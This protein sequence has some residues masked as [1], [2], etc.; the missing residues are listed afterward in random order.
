MKLSR[1]QVSLQGNA[2]GRSEWSTICNEHSFSETTAVA[3]TCVTGATTKR[4][5][6]LF[7]L[8]QD[9]SGSS[10]L[11]DASLLKGDCGERASENLRVLEVDQR[12]ARGESRT[13]HVRAVES[14]SHPH[15][16]DDYVHLFREEVAESD[17]RQKTE[18]PG[19]IRNVVRPV[20]LNK[21]IEP[22]PCEP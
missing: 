22:V 3:P 9:D 12:D 7:A 20:L 19:P 10:R 8:S 2:R 15:L 13:D 6:H 4:L 18:E 21:R 5:Q 14:T 17:Q 16:Q 1:R 11:E